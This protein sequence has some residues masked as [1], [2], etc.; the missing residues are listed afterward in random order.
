MAHSL[1]RS[2]GSA[3][4]RFFEKRR[5]ER[6]RT[7]LLSLDDHALADI[8]MKRDELDYREDPLMLHDVHGA[9]ADP[10]RIRRPH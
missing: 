5:E 7:E 1:M 4:T 8:G 9:P 2:I 3:I 10:D 6:T